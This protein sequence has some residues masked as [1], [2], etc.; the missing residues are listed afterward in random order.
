[1][2]DQTQSMG[3]RIEHES[4]V[5]KLNLELSITPIY[6]SDAIYVPPCL[7]IQKGDTIYRLLI[8]L[9]IFSTFFRII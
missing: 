7:R 6:F 5:I 8:V 9:L 4:R 3:F 1:M 2:H